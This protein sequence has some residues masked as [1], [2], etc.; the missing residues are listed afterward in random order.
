MKNKKNVLL[1]YYS[2]TGQLK[3]LAEKFV[4]PLSNHDEINLETLA[5]KPEVSYQFPWSFIRFFD[6][7]PETVRLTPAPII[8]PEFKQ[9]KYDLVILAYTVWFLSPAQPITAFLQHEKTKAILANTPIVTLI[10]CRNMWLMA[11]E[12]VKKHLKEAQ[13]NLVDNVVR[14]DSCGGPASFIA[15]PLWMF[16]GNKQ[17]VSWLPKAGISEEDI[18]ECAKYGEKIKSVLLTQPFINE[19]MLKNMAAVKVNERLI[20]SEKFGHRSFNFWGKWIIQAGTISPYLRHA[21]LYFYILFLI[22]VILTVVPISAL[23]KLL[24]SP[25]LKNKIHKQKRLFSW[26]SGE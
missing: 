19:P 11:Q 17:P 10:G 13:A 2:Q 21:L 20:L 25:W 12:T 23:I 16:T 15:T 24:L 4:S 6:T 1:V 14:I 9:Q 8:T 18:N 3:Q 5:I 26:P 22:T 7:F